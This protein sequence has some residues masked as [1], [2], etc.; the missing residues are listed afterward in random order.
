MVRK[1]SGFTIIEVSLF[2]ALSASIML[3]IILATNLSVARQRYNDSVNDFADFLRGIYSKVIDVEHDRTG[4]SGEA[5]YGK[6]VTFRETGNNT[7]TI[8]VYDVVGNVVNSATE[9]TETNI[10]EILKDD[11]AIN[12]SGSD[13]DKVKAHLR[14]ANG[15]D[16]GTTP[17]VVD[18]YNVPWDAVLEIKNSGTPQN[19]PVNDPTNDAVPT[20]CAVGSLLIVRSPVSGNVKTL[21]STK[22]I[23]LSGSDANKNFKKYIHPGNSN[24]ATSGNLS[25]S[26]F[27]FCID[28]DDN[29]YSN[30]RDIRVLGS[31]SNSSGVYMVEMDIAESGNDG[32]SR[33][34]GRSN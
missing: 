5:I 24:P 16:S 29:T 32:M 6:F 10:L 34:T 19:C 13:S 3:G 15:E 14:Q 26:D 30:R 4:N 33:C 22:R 8:K 17:L 28:S 23:N 7:K 1:K 21:V 9:I 2:L 25:S 20:G 18:T 11:S 31:G 12:P 27:D